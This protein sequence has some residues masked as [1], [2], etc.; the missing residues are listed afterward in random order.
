M[1]Q[2]QSW[3]WGLDRV[4][5]IRAVPIGG[6][7][8]NSRMIEFSF[9]NAVVLL[10]FSALCGCADAAQ[11]ASEYDLGVQAY[12]IKDYASA[13]RHWAN[14]IVEEH[15]RAA[16]NNLGYLLYFGL[17]GET[18][19]DQAISLWREA[20]ESGDRES[21]WHLGQATEDGKGV[22]QSF[23]KAYAWYR[24]ASTDS[25]PATDELDIQ[26]ARDASKSLARLLPELSP[27]EFE[28]GEKLAKLYIANYSRATASQ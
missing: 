15:E 21:Q 8:Q 7:F 14:A 13:R 4:P 19:I 25:P 24:C 3:L 27:V 28:A 23:I 20:A 9:K 10:C 12:R 6:A 11:K 26:V 5:D 22:E 18:D 2:K 17:G 1:G 16:K